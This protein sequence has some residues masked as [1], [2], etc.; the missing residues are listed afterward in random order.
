MPF[1][2]RRP[3]AA[4]A[5][6]ALALAACGGEG[7]D[8]A[9]PATTTVTPASPD[10]TSPAPAPGPGAQPL[11]SISVRLSPVAELEQ[12]VDLAVRA[13]DP[14]LYVVEK[15]GRVRAVRDGAVDEAPALDL[16]DDVSGA[17]EQGLL[18][19]T[20]APDGA[21]LYVNFTDTA[22]DTRIVEYAFAGGRADP[23][24]RRQ[25]LTIDQPYS[26]HNGGHLAFG[27]DGHLYVGTGDGGSANDPE[28]R[29][30]N[31]DSLLGKMLRV[32]PTPSGGRQ[33]TIP[34]GNPFV[35]QAGARGEIWAFGL[36]NPWRFSFDR[37][38]GDLWIGDVGQNAVEEIDFAPASSSGGE[39]Y[40]WPSMEGTLSNRGGRPAGAVDPILGYGHSDGGCSVVT[41]YVYR[42]T[43]IPSLTGALLYG[44][45]CA[46]DILALRQS[47]GAVTEQ[48]DLGID[49]TGLSSFGQD[50]AGELYALSINGT[51]YRI[52]PATSS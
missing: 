3:A 15:T 20:F 51:V 27:P 18:G 34:P 28:D 9:A 13:G 26:N 29:A 30:Q 37:E 36:R 48:A 39:N 32:D 43:T 23:S 45:F 10:P 16:R 5:A 1:R 38:T 44:D 2:R 40:G 41:G 11:D 17:G 19:L 25:L 6:V 7:D 52:V 31:L 12:P 22:G 46:G 4:L 8:A 24:T 42:G 33:Y 49:V 21:H 35:G 47:E 50:G 14:A